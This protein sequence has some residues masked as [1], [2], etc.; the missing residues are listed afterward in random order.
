M[1]GFKGYCRVWNLATNPDLKA[2]FAEV[3]YEPE[4]QR[5]AGTKDILEVLTCFIL[6]LQVRILP[7]NMAVIRTSGCLSWRMLLEKCCVA[8]IRSLAH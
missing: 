6:W 3:I 8:G 2:I 4:W 1:D 5:A 7:I